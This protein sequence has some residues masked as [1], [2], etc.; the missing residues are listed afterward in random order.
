FGYTTGFQVANPTN[1]DVVVQITYNR[2][3]GS[4]LGP[5]FVRIPAG[6]S[7]TN[8]LGSPAFPYGT[9]A[10]SPGV[11]GSNTFANPIPD[12]W[13]GGVVVVVVGGTPAIAGQGN[14]AGTVAG[15]ALSIYNAFPG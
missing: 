4:S 3:D 5:Y 12:N 2:D 7:L 11:V 8:F 14:F 9:S 15:D 13:N 10:G 1:A 6:Q